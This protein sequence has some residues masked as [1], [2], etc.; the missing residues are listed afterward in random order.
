MVRSAARGPFALALF[1]VA[2]AGVGYAQQRD[3]ADRV[4]YSPKKGAPVVDLD[5]NL[6][7]DAAGVKLVTNAGA[8][9]ASVTADLIV[10]TYPVD[11]PALPP[12]Q[13]IPLATLEAAKEWEKA[14]GGY[15][16]LKEKFKA[17]APDRLRRW[18]GEEV[19]L[20]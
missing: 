4:F 19:Q 2:S 11:I 8:V 13:L 15:E 17:G 18:L 5:A 6:K 20:A 9:K 12:E 16:G 10:R 3:G 14:R 7:Q 1:F